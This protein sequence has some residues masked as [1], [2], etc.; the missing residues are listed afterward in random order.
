MRLS[1]CPERWSPMVLSASEWEAGS[2]E[3]VR[4]AVVSRRGSKVNQ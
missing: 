1:Y 2:G 4:S 3:G